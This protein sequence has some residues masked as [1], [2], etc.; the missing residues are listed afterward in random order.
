[1][2]AKRTGLP[3]ML[4]YNV[5]HGRVASVSD[6]H[7]RMLFREPPPHR[8]LKKVDGG[9]FRRMVRLWLFLN[10]ELTRS[11]LYR[12]FY[13]TEHP[14]KPDLRIFSGKTRMI[15]AG[16]ERFMRKKFTD[17]GIDELLLDQW[18]DE[19]DEFPHSVMVS[20]S[21]IQPVL[22]YLWNHLGVHPTS[23]LNQTLDRYVS[24][25]LK[26]V[27][28]D[29]YDHARNLKRRTEKALATK[30]AREIERLKESI[31]GGKS[32][33]TPYLDIREELRFLRIH[34]KKSARHYLGR[35]IW[36]YETGRAKRIADWRA[37]KIIS[38]CDRFI[39][40]RPDIPFSALPRNWQRQWAQMLIKAMVGRL[41]Q[42][43]SR[44]EGIVFEKRI[45]A[46]TRSRDV[47]ANRY[48]G[49]TPFE[50]AP[51]ALGMRRK[52]FDMMV[53]RHCDI[54]RTVGIY[55]KRWYLSNLYLQELSQKSYFDLISA[56]YELLS[57]QSGGSG[58]S[59]PCMN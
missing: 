20:Y 36:T 26:R 43:L 57:R 18:L 10:E 12:E 48:N 30:D 13:G 29:I 51:T 32:G 34:T 6:R 19:F 9:L 28:R 44:Q 23:I 56:K 53:A 1:M 35:S 7:Y 25:E 40:A 4:V 59:N 8:Y 3:Y 39:R 46:P 37:R 2:L 55:A 45:L 17:A 27:S 24:G 41:A 50:M 33:Y 22:A 31:S 14:R 38:D 52:A 15:D 16:L 5:V 58:I 11:D 42:L 54:F 49:L 47:Y 21:R